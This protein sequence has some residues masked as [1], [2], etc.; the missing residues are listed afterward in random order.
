MA[1]VAETEKLL[2]TTNP[3]P[4]HAAA[5]VKSV[6]T[7]APAA[8]DPVPMPPASFTALERLTAVLRWLHFWHVHIYATIFVVGATVFPLKPS[9]LVVFIRVYHS[10]MLAWFSTPESKDVSLAQVAYPLWLVSIVILWSVSWSSWMWSTFEAEMGVTA[11]GVGALIGLGAGTLMGAAVFLMCTA[12]REVNPAHMGCA[13]RFAIWVHDFW[14]TFQ[15]GSAHLERGGYILTRLAFLVA[16][17]VVPLDGSRTLWGKLAGDHAAYKPIGYAAALIFTIVT[18]CYAWGNSGY[19]FVNGFGSIAAAVGGAVAGGG[20]GGGGRNLRVCAVY[21]VAR[22]RSR[23]D[24]GRRE[25]TLDFYPLR[26]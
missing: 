1:L 10:A 25:I 14:P 8:E 16:L 2:P 18:W 3:S 15:R 20:A 23:R 17:A 11:G 13:G 21:S 6:P 9:L 26:Y 22:R 7:V 4:V 24:G 5:A 19:T 12:L